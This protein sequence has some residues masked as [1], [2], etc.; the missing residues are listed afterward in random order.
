MVG[1]SLAGACVTPHQMS[2]AQRARQ[3]AVVRS[4][5]LGE[6]VLPKTFGPPWPPN[7]ASLLDELGRDAWI[8][9]LGGPVRRMPQ[10]DSRVFGAERPGERPAECRNGHCGVDLGGEI[11]GE[12]VHVAHDGVVDRVQRGPNED[13]GGS[14]V[15]IAHRNGT[16]FSQYFHL[17]ALPRRIAPGLRVKAGE[18]I[19]LLGDSGVKESSPHLHFTISVQPAK[20]WPEQYIDPEPLVALWPLRVPIGTGSA[21]TITTAGQPGV[22]LGSATAKRKR[23]ATRSKPPRESLTRPK[24]EAAGDKEAA[25]ESADTAPAEGTE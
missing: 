12:H 16:V 7:E 23:P 15:R 2:R 21:G 6:A 8:H 1:V 17:A 25:D 20:D 13:H 10:S 18:V 11:W 5:N 24:P 22:P 3:P 19:G 4:A 9:P 14:Y